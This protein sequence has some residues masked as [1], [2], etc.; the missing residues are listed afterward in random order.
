[1]THKF[2]GHSH[3]FTTTRCIAFLP[4]RFYT[5][6]CFEMISSTALEKNAFQDVA[7][8]PMQSK[9]RCPL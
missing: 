7:T 5:A 9:V 3:D 2:K 4:F 8:S 6:N 1:M